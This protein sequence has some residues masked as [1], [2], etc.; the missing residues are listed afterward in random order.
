MEK[1]NRHFRKLYS[2]IYNDI[3]SIKSP[4]VLEFGVSDQ[5]LSTKFFLDICESNNGKLYSV[6]V[7]DYSHKFNSSHWIFIH[8]KDDNFSLIEKKTENNQFNLIYLD[9]IHKANHIEKIVSYYYPK[10]VKKGFFLIDDISWLPYLKK[11]EKNQFY[12]ERNNEESFNRILEIFYAN[13]DNFDLEFSFTGTGLAK[14]TKLNNN[15]LNKPNKIS[16]RKYSLNN[17]L[18][19]T[20]LK[21]FK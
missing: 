11:S 8:S 13:R 5:A 20:Y 15:E 14:I 12:M 2:L 7:N 10:L 21:L 3:K 16:N 1:K 4:N 17:F 6:D 9:T 18:R 19:K